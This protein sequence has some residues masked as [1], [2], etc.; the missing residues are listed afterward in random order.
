M[1]HKELA[2]KNIV[3]LLFLVSCVGFSQSVTKTISG[4]ITD[5][6]NPME[7]TSVSIEGSAKSTF[8]DR[9]G[10]YSI[11]ATVGDVVQY[12]YQGM[13]TVKI[14]IEDVTRILNIDMVPD[15]EELEEVTVLGSNRKSQRELSLEYPSNLN[16][17]RTAYGYINA[18]TAPG[19]IRFMHEEQINP[20]AIC[21]LDLLQNEFAGVRVQG[22]CL[23][24]FGPGAGTSRQLT[25]LVGGNSNAP[26]VVGLAAGANA[27]QTA[28]I[29]GRVFIRGN[30]SIFNTRS[31]I[32]DVDG[33]I[34]TDAPIWIDVKNI[35]RIAILNNFATTTQYGSIGTGG[36]IVIN[37]IAASPKADKIYD[38]AR[39]RNNFVDGN[40][41]SQEAVSRN[42]P[43]YLTELYTSTSFDTAKNVY[44]KYA[45]T[46]SGSPYFTLDAQKYFVSQWNEKGYADDIVASTAAIFEKNPVLLKALAYQ[47]EESGDYAASNEYYKKVLRLR[48]NYGQS[49]LDLANSYRDLKSP[50][51]AASLYTRYTHLVEEG[52]MSLD[53]IGFGPIFEREYNNFL[54]LNK[55]AVV[56]GQQATE[57]YIAEEEFEGTRLV[58]EWNDSE[59]EFDL[60]FVNPK[61][62]YFLWKH[63]LS[64]NAEVISREKEY[65]YATTEY[66]ID[67]S[68]PGNWTV[69][70]NYYGNKSLTPT[71]LKAT[72]YYNYGSYAQRKE[73]RVFKLSLKNVPQELFTVSVGGKLVSR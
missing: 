61:K 17:I 49:Y 66:L 46:Y 24:A 59:A 9:N 56:A 13:K 18:E 68:L 12:S 63:S 65:G 11:S 40:I 3:L 23:G 48:P 25:N 45:K 53:S 31:A 28:L 10:K 67:G 70:I 54:F 5:G 72:V 27:Q 22:N 69:N 1:K 33:Q 36:V 41:V 2:M 39:L 30:N 52:F 42:W 60:Q 6:K 15:I 21:I 7:N 62:Q 8:S 64:S 19:K 58:F 26:G 34:F 29:N 16:I 71:Y 32:F 50:Q 44:E 37:T 14:R 35:Q 57:L 4:R 38:R 55:N 47:Y 73:T 20:V 43:N 51:Q